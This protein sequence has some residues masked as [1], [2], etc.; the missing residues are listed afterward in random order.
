MVLI[1]T[2]LEMS[3]ATFKIEKPEKKFDLEDLTS[4]IFQNH[5][6]T[7]QQFDE[8][9]AFYAQ[10]PQELEAIYN[11]VIALISSSQAKK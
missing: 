2:E 11:E 4:K 8:S 9:M 5:Q 3:Q 7:K 6:T 10:T 1:I